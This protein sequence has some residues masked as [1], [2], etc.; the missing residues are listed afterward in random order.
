MTQN[1]Q[2]IINL[3]ITVSTII[4]I[5]MSPGS[6]TIHK[7]P[8]NHE[9]SDNALINI[10]SQIDI[11]REIEKT[12]TYCAEFKEYINTKLEHKSI[13]TR[14]ENEILY[15]GKVSLE[16]ENI[17]L[18]NEIKSQ[19][20]IIQMLTSN[21]NGKNQW[22]SSTSINPDF[23]DKQDIPTSINLTNR[24]ERL[25]IT[26]ENSGPVDKNN[27][28]TPKNTIENDNLNHVIINDIHRNNN[29]DPL[30]VRN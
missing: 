4:P 2:E 23:L 28:V 7:T 19:Q 16:K 3:C 27:D 14:D 18:K 29:I 20:L 30:F 10:Q 25:Y 24:F 12:N 1:N 6:P 9:I 26:E 8:T 17:C 5:E 22:K 15:E 13:R 21:E 11:K